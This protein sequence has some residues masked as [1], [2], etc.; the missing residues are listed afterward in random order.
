MCR[1]VHSRAEKRVN[2]AGYLFASVQNVARQSVRSI[3]RALRIMSETKDSAESLESTSEKPDAE[4]APDAETSAS[5]DADGPKVEDVASNEADEQEG[6]EGADEDEGVSTDAG[7]QDEKTD[8]AGKSPENAENDDAELPE[9]EVLLPPGNPLRVVRGGSAIAGGVLAALI[10]MALRPQY[11][12]GVPLGFLAI[13]IATFGVLDLCGTFDDPDERVAK[14][15]H[16]REL[17]EP[18]AMFASS[19]LGFVGAICLA[20][21]GRLGRLRRRSSC[22]RA[23]CR[24]SWVWHGQPSGSACG[25]GGN[26]YLSPNDMVFGSSRS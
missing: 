15:L 2:A 11:R 9:G 24:R 20:V 18:L 17:A 25:R 14:R 26:H 19:T 3:V 5:P 6:A 8:S 22:R 4:T 1:D 21:A 13:L 12:L 16:W 10:L 23:F 7:A